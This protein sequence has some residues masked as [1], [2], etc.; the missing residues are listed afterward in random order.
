[1]AT[2]TGTGSDDILDGTE[3]A[4]SITG[5]AGNDRLRG[6]GGNDTLDGGDGSDILDGGIG[7]DTMTGGNDNDF[8]VVDDAGDLVVETA[9][10]G[11]DL[12]FTTIDYTLPGDVERGAVYSR[13]STF[14][15]NLTGN[16]L[17]NELIGND[18]ANVLRG[19]AGNDTL[20]GG[21]GDDIFIVEGMNDRVIDQQNGGFD[22]IY[23]DAVTSN[24]PHTGFDYS[25]RETV[26][27]P[28]AASHIE[29]VGV[30]DAS[31]TNS[32]NIIGSLGNN[33]LLG[34]NGA[35]MLDGWGGNDIMTGFGGDDI[36]FV[37][38]AGDVVV[39]QSGGGMDTVYL[40]RAI[41]F[42]ATPFTNYTLG[43]NIERL[44]P[45]LRNTTTAYVLTGNALDNEISGN[46]GTN[47]LDGGAGADLLIGYGGDDTYI[48]DNIGDRVAETAGGWS[49]PSNGGGLDTV[50]TSVDF[51]LG[52]F[53]EQL[54]VLDAT[55]TT[56]LDLT[57][58]ALV[59]DLIGNAGDNVIDGKAGADTMRGLGG[60]DIYFADHS[61]D[62]VHE[63]AGEGY[64]T[65]Y[66]S[67]ASFYRLDGNVER[68][69]INGS[70]TTYAIDLTG[71]DT[72]NE[73]HGN[74]GANVIDGKFGR[75]VLYGYGGADTFTF[76]SLLVGGDNVD[77]VVDFQVGVD[78]IALDDATFAGLTPGALSAN[79][80]RFG[81]EAQDADDR[82][83]YD[84][85]TGNLYFDS[86]GN[87][88]GALPIHFANLHE[89][90]A[91]TASD[92]FIV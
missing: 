70:S 90:L 59:N 25:I 87:G 21:L 50:R 41:G 33:E 61:V 63:N 73:I 92:F 13:A 51:T 52:D 86:D 9:T 84:S 36:Y 37:D 43:D 47:Q 11:S 53:V 74:D 31:T 35:N 45:A 67:S 38:A 60:N 26:N 12:V 62:T 48:V 46:D 68:L 3:D 64:D 79:A 81:T 15:I 19:G 71:N 22:T 72:D 65:V 28:Q 34:N 78:R 14:A 76:A 5:L 42:F 58:N 82:I 16:A 23:V 85:V 18:G 7:A 80:F 40:G 75:D 55:S 56:A 88:T 1:M 4:D 57:G 89:G 49:N 66:V 2:I 8:Y 39:E 44:T 54:W 91:L 32:V 20:Q 17:D 30:Y 24:T 77:Q 10:G 83:L 29:R 6:F 69:I 27:S